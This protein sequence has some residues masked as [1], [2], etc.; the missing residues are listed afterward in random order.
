[1]SV[2]H[3]AFRDQSYKKT[4][5]DWQGNARDIYRRGLG[6]SAAR[7]YR[8]LLQRNAPMSTKELAETLAPMSRKTVQ[9]AISTLRKVELVEAREN[10]R[11]IAHE[12]PTSRLDEIAAEHGVAGFAEAQAHRYGW[13]ENQA[14]E[15]CSECNSSRETRMTERVA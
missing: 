14:R 12:V 1:V 10:H 4:V 15:G 13:H 9:R 11:Y 3:E 8:L 6:L 2:L 7:V 5:A